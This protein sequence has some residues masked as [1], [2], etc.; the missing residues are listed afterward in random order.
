M[1]A[2]LRRKQ[3]LGEPQKNSNRVNKRC[4]RVCWPHVVYM[5]TSICVMT[6][7]NHGIHIHV[8]WVKWSI[9][10]ALTFYFSTVDV[11]GFSN[12]WKNVEIPAL[13]LFHGCT[14]SNDH[15]SVQYL[16]NSSQEQTWK[17]TKNCWNQT[18]VPPRI[19]KPVQR[20][21]PAWSCN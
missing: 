18:T 21:Y 8:P 5:Y 19:V 20:S 3:F 14:G 9:Y 13:L 10:H 15:G 1:N 6:K 4:S 16:L 2:L 11:E 7:N 12:L 17:N